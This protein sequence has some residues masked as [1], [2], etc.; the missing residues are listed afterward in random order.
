MMLESEHGRSEFD[1][2]VV[3]MDSADEGDAR[4][5]RSGATLAHELR[6][7]LGAIYNELFILKRNH[8]RQDQSG[9]AL[10]MM[11]RLL[12][13]LSGRIDDLLD[14]GL[15]DSASPAAPLNLS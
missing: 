8:Q 2:H 3:T 6:G 7:P 10:S 13:R 1:A 15:A 11:E 4:L 9:C 5:E 14:V 12:E